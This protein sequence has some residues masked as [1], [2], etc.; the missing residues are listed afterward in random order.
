MLERTS[1]RRRRSK[2]YKRISQ[3]KEQHWDA[4]LEGIQQGSSQLLSCFYL[5]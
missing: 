2:L 5:F 1:D 3:A 4:F